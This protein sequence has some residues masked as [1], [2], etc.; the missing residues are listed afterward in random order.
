MSRTARS[1]AMSAKKLTT[2]GRMMG[3]SVPAALRAIG[4]EIMTDAKASS[5]GRGV[6]VDL[7]AL[8]AS[9]QVDGPRS[10][11]TVLLSFGDSS[12][13][14]ALVQHE[15]LDY[16]HEIGEARYLVRPVDRWREDGSAAMRGLALQAN[17]V[18]ALARRSA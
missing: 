12:T 3:A 1:F 4:E 9:G 5:P 10:D 17:A 7:G 6:P 2:F 13:D 11:G 15:N 14:Y 18:A 16:H 8:R